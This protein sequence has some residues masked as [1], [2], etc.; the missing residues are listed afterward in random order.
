MI[1]DIYN[2]HLQ[3]Q[4]KQSNFQHHH[5]KLEE[6]Y[7]NII[8]SKNLPELEQKHF[9]KKKKI[10]QLQSYHMNLLTKEKQ[11]KERNMKLLDD[12]DHMKSLL[13]TMDMKTSMLKEAKMSCL[14]QVE[15]HYPEWKQKLQV[16]RAS[17]QLESKKVFSNQIKTTKNV[18]KFVNSDTE[19]SIF[20]KMLPTRNE[21]SCISIDQPILEKLTPYLKSKDKSEKHLFNKENNLSQNPVEHF[22]SE[23]EIRRSIENND[24]QLGF[25]PKQNDIQLEEN[26]LVLN[27][28]VDENFQTNENSEHKNIAPGNDDTFSENSL[29]L[30]NQK[31]NKES[32][33]A[34]NC[35][36]SSKLENNLLTKSVT[37]LTQSPTIAY[38]E[39]KILI[40]NEDLG[41]EYEQ[42][43]NDT[44]AS[45]PL[46][47][48]KHSILK[49]SIVIPDVRES[50]LG[51]SLTETNTSSL[52]SLNDTQASAFTPESTLATSAAYQMFKTKIKGSSNKNKVQSNSDEESSMSENTQDKNKEPSSDIGLNNIENE[53]K[54]SLKSVSPVSKAHDNN[55]QTVKPLEN[56]FRKSIPKAPW[57]DSSDEDLEVHSFSENNQSDN[58]DDFYD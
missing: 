42:K 41:V 47:G 12:F 23:K 30:I 25:S 28:I 44:K 14:K 40:K 31:S 22:V 33:E 2:Q 9:L 3:F 8:S 29:S 18:E 55:Q 48:Q 19:T 46:E 37:N 24:E 26:K 53:K 51:S 6:E 27:E 36:D 50:V 49:H 5:I 39:E 35:S 21:T 45:L 4:T 20:N 15:L 56:A 43:V 57:E 58:D 1:M 7:Q 34:V 13:K 17:K 52:I 10:E 11:A 16:A 54:E 32:L 38:Q